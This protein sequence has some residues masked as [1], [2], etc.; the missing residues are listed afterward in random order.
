MTLLNENSLVLSCFKKYFSGKNV[1]E[2]R[3]V[4]LHNDEL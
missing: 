4:I 3:C 1:K 2:R